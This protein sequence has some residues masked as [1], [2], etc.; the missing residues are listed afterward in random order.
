LR[1]SRILSLGVLVTVLL[2]D[3]GACRHQPS[4]A[5]PTPPIALSF[6]ADLAL[7]AAEGGES[8]VGGISAVSYVP[9]TG[10]WLALSDARVASRFY[11]V[12]VRFDGSALRIETVAAVPLTDEDGRAFPEDVLD[13]E[14]MSLTP[15]GNL[16]ISTEPDT[17]H[18]PVEQAKLLEV[19]RSGRLVRYVEI[20]REFSVTGRPPDHGLRHNLG[21]EALGLSP[22]GTR[23]FVGSEA[24]LAQDGPAADF[25]HAGRCR[26]LVY[27]VGP[28]ERDLTPE[29][30]LVYPIGPFA[31]EP[32][33]GDQEVS[34]GLVELA[35]LSTSHLLALERVYV[36]ELSS[37]P[38]DRTRSRIYQIDVSE[39]TNVLGLPSLSE[40][41]VVRPVAKELLLDLD[42][43]LSALSRSY[44]K[45]DNLEAMGLG[46]PLPPRQGGGMALLLVSDDNF[47]KTQRTQF[48]L[49]RLRVPEWPEGYV[50]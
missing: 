35:P 26:I 19:D 31:R 14:G 30:E 46:P 32:G 49:F 48:L 41:P 12:E 11:E 16:L 24:T 33:F 9:E 36:R 37:K 13:P 8:A 10:R 42:D 28:G 38:R 39:A 1:P 6:L 44:P 18:D 4:G 17:R 21:F 40:L 47:R 5:G 22:D 43:I 50:K 23:V 25:S 29:A 2:V 15:W 3:V 27:R 34:G 20:P 45:L 7:P